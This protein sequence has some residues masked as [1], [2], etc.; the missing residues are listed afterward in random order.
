M[1]VN[2]VIQQCALSGFVNNCIDYTEMKA[3]K[4]LTACKTCSNGYFVGTSVSSTSMC[5]P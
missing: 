2:G 5:I 3:D 4:S 1:I